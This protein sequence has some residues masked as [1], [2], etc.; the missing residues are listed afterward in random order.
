MSKTDWNELINNI[1][2]ETK[3][4]VGNEMA[5]INLITEL[6]YRPDRMW[7]DEENELLNKLLKLAGEHTKRQLKEVEEST[8]LFVESERK[9]IWD[10]ACEA[11]NE[12]I[13]NGFND[14]LDKLNDDPKGKSIFRQ[15]AK[16]IKAYPLAEYTVNQIV[17]S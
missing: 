7:T 3:I 17:K 15:I 9:R 13:S 11:Q 10:K 1:P 6:G 5:F 16:S 14:N 2:L 12:N 8:T 4:K